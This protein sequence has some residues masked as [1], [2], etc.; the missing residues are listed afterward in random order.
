MSTQA[1]DDFWRWWATASEAFAEA[2]VS[3]RPMGEE[4][5]QAMS[6]HVEAIDASLDWEFGAGARAKHH[7][8]L[9]AKGDPV[10]RVVAER[11]VKRGPAPDAT[12]EYHAAR[13]AARG[14]M[15]LEIGGAKVELAEMV[16]AIEVDE[17]VE[18]IHVRGHHPAF[19]TIEDE[20]LR[21][22][23]LF[24]ALDRL[25]GEDGVER[26]VGG[27]DASV[28]AL[29]G[30][31]PY[32]DLKKRVDALAARATGD[33]WAVLSGERQGKPIFITVN[34]AL[35]RVDHLLLDMHAMV[36]VPLLA[37]TPAGLTTREEAEA[38]D[39]AEDELCATLGEH[40]VLVGRETCEGR[41]T[42]HLHVAEGGPSRGLIERWAARYP[43]RTVSVETAMDPRWE[44]LGRWG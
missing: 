6:A 21:G 12:W 32:R 24:I 22:Q 14:D 30:A 44:V 33:R 42:I 36:D 19:A 4:L 40:G 5:I 38:L 2:F 25:L 9:S 26:W 1:I 23:I 31:L 15:S 37:P 41:R 43:D 18:R 7:L 35:K 17:A 27:I 29:P 10:T 8:C 16:F 11:W 34:R 39:D 20:A 28:E 13:Q 3:G